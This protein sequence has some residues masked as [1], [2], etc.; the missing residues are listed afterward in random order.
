MSTY[1]QWIEHQGK[2]I[3][4]SNY[5]GLGGEEY[6]RAIDE[7]KQELLKQPVGSRVLTLTDTSDSHATEA[8][9]DKAKEQQS[10]IN[11]KG[12]T[13]H[14]A[15]V[16]VSRWQK[17]IAQLIRRDVY[18]AQSIEDAKDWLVEQADK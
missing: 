9:R 10:A 5:S 16:G 6:E 1:V 14:A 15:I 12:I 11:E 4:F 18:F 8:T 3:L 2:N 17:V 7:T 13:T